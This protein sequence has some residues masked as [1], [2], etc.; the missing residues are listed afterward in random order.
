VI[1]SF[2]A[3]SEDRQIAYLP[4]APKFIQREYRRRS[5]TSAAGPREAMG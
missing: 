2:F 4:Y 5:G 1:G 3:L